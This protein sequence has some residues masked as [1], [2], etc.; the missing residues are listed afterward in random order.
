MLR[1]SKKSDYGLIALKHIAYEANGSPVNAREIAEAYNLPPDLLAK[2]L[3]DLKRSGIISSRFGSGGGYR[4][5]KDPAK[6]TLRD[7]VQSI[8]GPVRFLACN[9]GRNKCNLTRRCTVR[10]R[11]TRFEKD[12]AALL[13]TVT[14]ADL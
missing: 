4:M 3:Q 10:K 12:L 8:D 1:L 13:D 14:L 5:A 9:T 7:V 11:L 6:V 2:V